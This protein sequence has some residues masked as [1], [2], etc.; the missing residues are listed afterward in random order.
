MMA[1]LVVFYSCEGDKITE[2]PSTEIGKVGE[3]NATGLFGETKVEGVHLVKR[4]GEADEQMVDIQID[5]FFLAIGHKP[6]SDVFKD[7]LETDEVGY[8][9]TIDGTPRTKI[10]GVF[11]AGDVADPVYRQAIT[12]A[13][14]GCKAALEAERYLL[15]S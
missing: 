4:K 1:C 10:P 14:S 11:V 2:Q 6:N 5:G 13:A 7:W 8:I 12:A 3:H 15:N 9:K